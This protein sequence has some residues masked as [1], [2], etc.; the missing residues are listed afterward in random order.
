MMPIKCRQ[1]DID[2][3]REHFEL[4]DG[5]VYRKTA[6]GLVPAKEYSCGKGY[7]YVCYAKN[8]IK[9]HR[10]VWML[11]YGYN[12]IMLDH[13][14]G[15]KTDNRIE[16]LREVTNRENGQNMQIHREGRLPG[17]KRDVGTY[18]ARISIRT[19]DN[20]VYIGP[21]TTEKDAARAYGAACSNLHL[22]T[23]SATAFRKALLAAKIIPPFQYYQALGYYW[24]KG[25]N[26]W[27]VQI[28]IESKSTYL[29]L[30]TEEADAAAAY[31][32]AKQL[33]KTYKT[34]E[35]FQAAWKQYKTEQGVAPKSHQ[36]NLLE[37]VK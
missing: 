22:Y 3:L 28:T 34:P 4:V 33:R 23:G 9:S 8:K 35:A 17:V 27:Q 36:I 24:D 2:E 16:N 18:W 29:G 32:A 20:R 15:D 26:K 12:P 19:R 31:K 37:L 7:T 13:I 6:D 25:N 5:K 30:Y 14:N 11:H 21:Y 10:L 1:W